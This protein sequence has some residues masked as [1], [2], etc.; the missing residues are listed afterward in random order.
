MFVVAG[1]EKSLEASSEEQKSEQKLNLRNEEMHLNHEYEA[2]EEVPNF[3]VMETVQG[4]PIS[5]LESPCHSAEVK[6]SKLLQ[7]MQFFKD[8][9]KFYK[10][11]ASIKAKII[12]LKTFFI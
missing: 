6:N 10:R 8:K 7:Q 12:I 1:S 5:D 4:L 11:K 2:E 3:I 9:G